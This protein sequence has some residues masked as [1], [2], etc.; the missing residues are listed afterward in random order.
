[1]ARLRDI[2][3]PQDYL[4]AITFEPLAVK[5]EYARLAADRAYWNE[6]YA[7]AFRE[8]LTA[9]S[10]L[11]RT[12]ARVAL[13][14]RAAAALSGEKITEGIVEAKV[15]THTDVIAAVENHITAETERERLRGRLNALQDKKE[16]TTAYGRH[17]LEE[18]RGD[19]FLREQAAREA[20]APKVKATVVAINP[21]TTEETD[22]R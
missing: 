8:S 13:E 9:K 11:E 18:L 22:D 14:I 2:D 3:V 15:T 6:V 7:N 19:P 17:V 10:V 20:A 1:M 21:Q 4:D 16:A 5:E 12:R